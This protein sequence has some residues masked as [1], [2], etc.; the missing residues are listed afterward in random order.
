M[1]KVL[2][3]SMLTQALLIYENKLE[4][5]CEEAVAFNTSKDFEKK[6]EKLIKSQHSVYARLTL[7]KARK[8]ILVAALVAVLLAAT[9][10][11]GANR[12][13]IFSFFVTREQQL[14]ITSYEP[15][16]GESF[17]EKIDKPLSPSYVP[18]GYS[19]EISDGDSKSNSL[20]YT[21]GDD[22]LSIE[23]FVK[24]EYTSA[25]DAEFSETKKESRDG[26]D[27]IVRKDIDDGM[28]MLVFE[29][30]GYVFELVGFLSEEEM[31]KTAQSLE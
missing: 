3:N 19:L 5:A 7:T 26:V 20:L 22:Y 1:D 25:T 12:K 15:Q 23:Q 24:S 31:F 9:L 28:T 27:Y 11:V 30:D 18:E 6:M 13:K 2:D 29:K 8:L 16:A 17:P 14:E 10:S 21:D 4:R